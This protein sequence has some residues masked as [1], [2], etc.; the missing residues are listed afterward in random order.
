M[1][2]LFRPLGVRDELRAALVVHR[3]CWGYLHLFRRA[4]FTSEETRRI[5]QLA[6]LFATAL[7]AA[8]LVG[9]K[10]A[11]LPEPAVVVVTAQH[12]RLSEGA[13][14][15]LAGLEADV[16]G[17]TPHPLMTVA[18][19]IHHGAGAAQSRYRT[20]RG[21][22]ISFSGGRLGRDVA[23]TLSAP[24]AAELAPLW[25]LAHGLSVRERQICALLL[26]GHSNEA[27]ATLLQLGLYTV[28]D[29]VKAI[30][31]KTGA[32]TRGALVAGLCV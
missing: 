20:P 21:D 2:E 4:P 7:R 10:S 17:S 3:Y 19:R 31:R 8:C 12:V 22:W 28:K 23:L 30:L 15:W 14:A 16:G 18:A 29:H 26:D 32:P 9:Q 1:R 13:R 25:G 5:E 11:I 24:H 27:I 6:P